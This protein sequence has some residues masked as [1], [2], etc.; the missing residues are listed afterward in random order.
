MQDLVYFLVLRRKEME[1]T[2]ADNFNFLFL[3]RRESWA[4]GGGCGGMSSICLQVKYK[5]DVLKYSLLIRKW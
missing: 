5:G 3:Y 4:D 2:E 1:C